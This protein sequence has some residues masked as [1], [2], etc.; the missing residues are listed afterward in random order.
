MKYEKENSY[1]VLY[2]FKGKEKDD[3]DLR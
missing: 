1:V 2:H 3:M